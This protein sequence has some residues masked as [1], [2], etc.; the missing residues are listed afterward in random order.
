MLQFKSWVTAFMMRQGRRAL[1]E[2]GWQGKAYYLAALTMMLT[3][4]GMFVLQAREIASVNDPQDMSMDNKKFYLEALL[5][6]G[7]LGIYGD[8]FK[9][10]LKPDGRGML[11]LLTGPFGSDVQ[12]LSALTFGNAAQF[13]DEKNMNAANELIRF[14]KAHFPFANLWYT[15]AATDRMIFNQ[16]QEAANP[17]YLQRKEARDRRKFDRTPWWGSG[18]ALPERAPDWEKAVGE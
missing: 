8:I 15:K 9:A 2:D 13:Y 1:S 14:I 4:G 3:V 10:G 6:G 11:E 18:D 7:G 12:N 16:A 17:G 5:A